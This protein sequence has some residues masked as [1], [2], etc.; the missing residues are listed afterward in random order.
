ML[1]YTAHSQHFMS[2]TSKETT[3]LKALSVSSQIVIKQNFRGLK[4]S[5]CLNE[6]EIIKSKKKQDISFPACFQIQM[7]TFGVLLHC[8]YSRF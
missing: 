4:F 3:C 5:I 8:P 1:D 7:A 6:R 2:E